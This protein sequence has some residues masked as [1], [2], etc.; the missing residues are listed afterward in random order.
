VGFTAPL[1]ALT[2]DASGNVLTGR[3]VTWTSSNTAVASVSSAGVVTG[4]KVGTATITATSE[5][6]TGT[7]TVTVP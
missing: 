6:K 3:V 5:G 7:A 1:T 2:R 4:V